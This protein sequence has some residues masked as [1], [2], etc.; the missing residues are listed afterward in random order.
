[1]EMIQ[2]LR[3]CDPLER[4]GAE[5]ALGIGAHAALPA[6]GSRDLTGSSPVL[7]S[8]T[9]EPTP[10]AV[11]GT[12]DD[13]ALMSAR[14]SAVD[15]M[16]PVPRTRSSH[17]GVPQMLAN[18]GIGTVLLRRPLR[19]GAAIM[20]ALACLAPSTHARILDQ[21]DSDK[22]TAIKPSFVR[23]ATDLVQTSKRTD[24]SAADAE[25][26]DA[27]LRE[28]TQIG[29]ELGSYEHL[30]TIEDRIEDLGN[31][32]AMRGILRFAVDK[33]LVILDIEQKR[34]RQLLELCGHLPLSAGKAR[35]ALQF[36]DT[37][38]TVLKSIRPRL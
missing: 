16:R 6:T 9:L 15:M 27:T 17:E 18:F 26:I 23:L 37:T 10:G 35:D 30:I 3:R 22:V 31:D 14:A 24:L 20:L 25:C 19:I 1:H 5:E 21:S 8:R 28:M 33:A 34:M 29:D 12:P 32:A 2:L 13:P 36:V 4:G 7:A 11:A 38:A